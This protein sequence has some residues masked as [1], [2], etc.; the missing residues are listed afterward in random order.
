MK[1]VKLDIFFFFSFSF[2]NVTD[3]RGDLYSWN[4]CTP[5]S[6][7]SN[8]SECQNV[9]VSIYAA[10]GSSIDQFSDRYSFSVPSVSCLDNQVT[11]QRAVVGG[12]LWIS[13]SVNQPVDRLVIQSRGFTSCRTARTIFT[14]TE[15]ILRIFSSMYII[16]HIFDP[17]AKVLGAVKLWSFENIRGHRPCFWVKSYPVNLST[18]F[19]IPNIRLLNWQ[20]NKYIKKQLPVYILITRMHVFV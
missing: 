6:Y 3:A 18:T 4:P 20:E 11:N 14:A 10:F 16:I 19:R 7:P 9:A 15:L 17:S 8:D 13:M 1:S 2:V 5:F 12:W